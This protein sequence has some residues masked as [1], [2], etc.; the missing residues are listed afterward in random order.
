MH[1][2][3]CYNSVLRCFLNCKFIRSNRSELC[4][5]SF[6]LAAVDSNDMNITT[7]QHSG[8]CNVETDCHRLLC[9]NCNMGSVC[10]NWSM[11]A[12]GRKCT[13]KSIAIRHRSWGGLMPIQ[14]ALFLVIWGETSLCELQ[15]HEKKK[16]DSYQSSAV[17][18]FS[19]CN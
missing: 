19:F 1:I 16:S 13:S 15:W 18:L 6:F 2:T 9:S 12:E 10:T 8:I 5:Q 4:K 11:H 17:N 14:A 3:Y 7:F